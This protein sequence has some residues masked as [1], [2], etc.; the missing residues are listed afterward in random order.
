MNLLTRRQSAKSL[1]EEM[2]K[3]EK[4][5]Y[6]FLLRNCKTKSGYK[7]TYHVKDGILYHTEEALL[8]FVKVSTTSFTSEFIELDLEWEIVN[9]SV[10]DF[11]DC[12]DEHDFN[13]FD[14]DDK[15]EVAEII[16]ARLRAIMLRHYDVSKVRFN[17]AKVIEL[18]DSYCDKRE[19][20]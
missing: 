1:V 12:P 11:F 7:I 13:L 9:E 6:G 17:E 16:I 15:K 3:T 19:D 2:G 20:L 10:F 4:Y 8:Q 18:I 14:C 5:W